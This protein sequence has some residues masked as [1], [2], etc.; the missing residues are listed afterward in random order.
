GWSAR[1]LLGGAGRFSARVARRFLRRLAPRSQVLA[2]LLVDLAHAELDLAAIADLDDVARLGDAVLRQLADMDEAVAG[3]EEVHKGAEIDDLD[4]LAG[5]D[6][7]QLRLGDD[8]ADPVDRRLRR[9]RVDRGD[10][11]RAVVLDVDLGAGGL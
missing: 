2:G 10:L 6:D 3:A 7:S 8:A 5:I 9:R 11:D 4:H 1:R